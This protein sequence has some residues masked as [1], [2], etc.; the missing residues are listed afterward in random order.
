MIVATMFLIILQA[1]G[2]V[3]PPIAWIIFGV[4]WVLSIAK[5]ID[6]NKPKIKVLK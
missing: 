3:I 5:A 6:D 4:S 1:N 2:F